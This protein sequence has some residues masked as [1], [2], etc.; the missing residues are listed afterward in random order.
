MSLDYDFEMLL[1]DS[2]HL[3]R[4]AAQGL[5]IHSPGVAVVAK[6]LGGDALYRCSRVHRKCHRRRC[7]RWGSHDRRGIQKD[8][9]TVQR[10][11][12]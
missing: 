6:T 2:E 3:E 9:R 4:C 12:R 10:L 8:S 7:A 1:E 5:S 11:G